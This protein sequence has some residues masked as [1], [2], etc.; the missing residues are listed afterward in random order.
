MRKEIGSNFY[1]EIKRADTTLRRDKHT[2]L[3]DT[4]RSAI[5]FLLKMQGEH[6][7]TVLLPMYTCESIVV[8]FEEQH[9]EIVFYPINK[10][11]EP[12]K[13]SLEQLVNLYN[14]DV[15]F[16]QTYFG[17]DTL[18][19]IR[20]FLQ[21]MREKKI[22]I[23][24]DV[25][26][27]MYDNHE[28]SCVDYRLLSLRKWCS[29]PDGGILWC[30]KGFEESVI[31]EY[32]KLSENTQYV[33]MRLQAQENKRRYF[34]KEADDSWEEKQSFITLFDGSEEM[35]DRQNECYTM[36]SYS[37]ER[38]LGVDWKQDAE[39]RKSNFFYL[40]RQLQG[41]EG[42]EFLEFPMQEGAVPLYFPVFLRKDRDELRKY[43]RSQDV[44]LAVIW[45]LPESIRKH[46]VPEVKEIYDE[47][48][49]IPCDQRYTIDDMQVIVKR[50]REWYER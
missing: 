9:L 38:I 50:I 42:I 39:R 18:K 22:V 6:W 11:L 30:H 21:K 31:Q 40:H 12:D 3:F 34:E 8:P 4:G 45:P 46:L 7:K 10:R 37:C 13:N 32:D 2:L 26:H 47:I 48:L 20:S 44:L 36:S 49:V 35:L 29:I 33:E 24:E 43:L 25:T 14:P 17:F 16:V 23:I 19:E 5:R 28:S 41:I 15:I 1:E 27:S